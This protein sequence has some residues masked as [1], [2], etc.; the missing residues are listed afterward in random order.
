MKINRIFKIAFALSLFLMVSAALLSCGGG[1]GG[2]GGDGGTGTANTMKLKTLSYVDQQGIGTEAFRMLIPSDWNFEGG[3]EWRF[4]NP[5]APAVAK[6]WVRE[7]NGKAELQLLPAQSFFS[8]EDPTVLYYFPVGS[9]YYGNEV[10]PYPALGPS[11]TLKQIIIPRFRGNVTNLQIVSEQ[12]LPEVADLLRAGLPAQPNTTTE[13]AMIRI[14]Y[15]QNGK[16]MEEEI[17]CVIETATFKTYYP[18]ITYN[19]TLWMAD[20]LFSFKAEKGGLDSQYKI[21]QTMMYSFRLNPQWF[22]K[23]VQLIDYLVQQQI[24]IIQDW[25][26]LSEYISQTSDDISDMVWQSYNNRNAANDRMA[27]DF[28]HYLN[29]TD[30]YYNPIDQNTVELPSGYSD[31]WVNGLGEY[32]LSDNVNYNPNIGSGQNWQRMEVR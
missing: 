27:D 14:E 25:G 10:R 18:L 16:P 24:T 11:E 21:F 13:A 8:T 30:T 12:S 22:N 17:Y 3:I 5:G 1:G 15:E 7:P 20:Y 6:F 32:I 26:K 28:S 31:A 23:Y 9:K 4:D 19:N 29:G 2:G